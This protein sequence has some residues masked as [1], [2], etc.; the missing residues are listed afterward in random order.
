VKS[1]ALTC[2]VVATTVLL[3]G[4]VQHALGNADAIAYLGHDGEQESVFSIFLWQFG[5]FSAVSWLLFGL[6]MRRR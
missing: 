4:S 5:G 6:L 1:V 2:A 3:V